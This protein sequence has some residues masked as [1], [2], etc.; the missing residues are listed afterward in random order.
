MI[1]TEISSA[2]FVQRLL[3]VLDVSILESDPKKSNAKISVDVSAIKW[4]DVDV[5]KKKK[6]PR[7]DHPKS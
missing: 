4:W 3:P 2:Q 6:L 1:H 5:F 7:K